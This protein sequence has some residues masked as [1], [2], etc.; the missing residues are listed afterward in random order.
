MRGRKFDKLAANEVFGC[1]PHG[2]GAY[3]DFMTMLL[4]AVLID[5]CVLIG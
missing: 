3:L 4:L 1:I 2:R 5:V